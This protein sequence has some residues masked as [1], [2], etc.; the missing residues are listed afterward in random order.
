MNKPAKQ[1]TIT[2]LSDGAYA[3]RVTT[4][5]TG[6]NENTQAITSNT[7]SDSTPPAQKVET[8]SPMANNTGLSFILHNPNNEAIHVQFSL[9]PSRSGILYRVDTNIFDPE[10][11][12][13]IASTSDKSVSITNLLNGIEYGIDITTNDAIG[14]QH[15]DKSEVQLT[16]LAGI[17]DLCSNNSQCQAGV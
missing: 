8:R 11:E 4:F 6:S 15:A 9:S 1:T 17:D 7:F 16:P 12:L 10:D 2:N 14:N 13:V 5:D 3:F